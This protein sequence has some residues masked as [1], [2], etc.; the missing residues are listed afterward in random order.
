MEDISDEESDVGRQ[1]QNSRNL[2]EPGAGPLEFQTIGPKDVPTG[3]VTEDASCIV[4]NPATLAVNQVAVLED[5]AHCGR[6]VHYGHSPSST[7]ESDVIRRAEEVI[8]RED[9]QSGSVTFK[10][11]L[12]RIVSI[13]KQRQEKSC[14]VTRSNCRSSGETLVAGGVARKEGGSTVSA[15]AGI[16]NIENNETAAQALSR[17]IEKIDFGNMEVLGQFNLGFIIVRRRKP[18]STLGMEEAQTMDDLFIIDQH[19]ADEKYNF[20]TLQQTTKIQSQ[21]LFKPQPLELTAAD[22]LVAIENVDALRQNGF[23]LEATREEDGC[24]SEFGQVARLRLVAQPVSKSTTFD[25]KDL[26][27]LI[28]LLRERS[29]GEVVRCSKVRAMFAMRACRKSVMIGMALTKNQMSTLVQHMGLIDQPWN[30]PHGRPTMRHLYDLCLG[31]LQETLQPI[32]FASF[33]APEE[34]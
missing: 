32:N 12:P 29:P 6:H 13:W 8:R 3:G 31:S 34:D 19:A 25:M 23:E 11:N 17:V 30:C 26:E 18:G 5:N 21:R 28:H 7:T 20:E 2:D 24:N 16:S 22:E 14:Q 15:D 1:K 27:E 4:S 33:D 9:T 10:F